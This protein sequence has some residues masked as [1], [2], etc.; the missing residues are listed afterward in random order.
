MHIDSLSERRN[1]GYGS[2]IM[3]ISIILIKQVN[4]NLNVR[5]RR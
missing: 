2:T 4:M 1:I 5:E 3:Y